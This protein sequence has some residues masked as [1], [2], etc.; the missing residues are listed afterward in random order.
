MLLRSLFKSF[1]IGWSKT[2]VEM[3]VVCLANRHRA[4][5][6]IRPGTIITNSSLDCL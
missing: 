2:H 3:S 6:R 4:G 1:R 5:K